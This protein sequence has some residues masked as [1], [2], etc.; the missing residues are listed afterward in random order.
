MTDKMT[1]DEAKT[2]FVGQRYSREIAIQIERS[3]FGFGISAANGR[4]AMI[5]KPVSFKSR[6]DP[7]E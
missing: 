6:S 4:I 5:Y 7:K 3:G 1:L 2:A